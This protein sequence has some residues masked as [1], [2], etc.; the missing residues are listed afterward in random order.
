MLQQVADHFGGGHMQQCLTPFPLRQGRLCSYSADWARR[1]PA[2]TRNVWNLALRG[3]VGGARWSV[4]FHQPAWREA[5]CDRSAG[6]VSERGTPFHAVKNAERVLPCTWRSQDCV[7]ARQEAISSGCWYM[8]RTL[9]IEPSPRRHPNPPTQPSLPSHPTQSSDLCTGHC[10]TPLPIFF[11]RMACGLLLPLRELRGACISEILARRTSKWALVSSSRKAWLPV[12]TPWFP[13]ALSVSLLCLTGPVK[14]LTAPSWLCMFISLSR[15][16]SS[17]GSAQVE[18]FCHAGCALYHNFT[19]CLFMM[20]STFTLF[21]SGI[22]RL[23][24]LSISV[25]QK[26]SSR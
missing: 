1:A 23:Q 5:T 21:R 16:K 2:S 22:F 12:T 7:R 25:F 26:S 11:V 9:R 24:L 6:I 18:A 14:E 13:A 20:R 17:M 4:A 19:S 3:L 10:A 8:E 15:E